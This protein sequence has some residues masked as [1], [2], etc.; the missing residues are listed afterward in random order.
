MNS[1]GVFPVDS[2]EISDNVQ[3]QTGTLLVEEAPVYRKSVSPKS[4]KDIG[5]WSFHSRMIPED[6]RL[7]I[8]SRNGVPAT[9]SAPPSAGGWFGKKKDKKSGDSAISDKKNLGS[10]EKRK[11]H[12]ADLTN[13]ESVTI[14]PEHVYCMDFYDAYFDIN[15]IS[16]KLPGI[17]LSAFKYWEG[18]PLRFVAK[19]RTDPSKVYFTV[20]FE[21]LER[22]LVGVG[23]SVKCHN[24]EEGSSL[25]PP[26]TKKSF[27]KNYYVL[28]IFPFSLL[29]CTSMH[30]VPEDIIKSAVEE[31]KLEIIGDGELAERIA[32]ARLT[33]D[34]D[35]S[36]DDF[37]DAI[38]S[39][40][41]MK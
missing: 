1:I 41:A 39:P 2:T 13:R 21:I 14:S 34:D 33:D 35:E 16:L 12:F 11:K 30:Q 22:S 27:G 26:L 7:L 3:V 15:T 5:K 9:E 6:V 4:S 18:Q 25:K 28:F 24:D 20:W 40:A 29:D 10:Y 37:K 17:S 36:E 31:E 23:P 19:S 32:S 8:E 38:E